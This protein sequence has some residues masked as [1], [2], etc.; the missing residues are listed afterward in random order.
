ML[1]TAYNTVIPS[2]LGLAY[3]LFVETNTFTKCVVIFKTLHFEHPKVTFSNVNIM[4][5]KI[6]GNKNNKSKISSVIR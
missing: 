2:H 4:Q 5:K 3:A 6:F 1:S